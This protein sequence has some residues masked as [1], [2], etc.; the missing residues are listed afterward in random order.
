MLMSAIEASGHMDKVKLATDL[1][2]SEFYYAN[3][4][5][6]DLYWKDKSKKGTKLMSSE[7]LARSLHGQTQSHWMAFWW[8]VT[9]VRQSSFRRI[10]IFIDTE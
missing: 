1:A 9:W 6:Y 3:E 4:K 5:K 10:T 2:A 7:E 8:L